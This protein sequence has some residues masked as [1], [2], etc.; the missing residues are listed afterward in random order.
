MT[1]SSVLFALG[2]ALSWTM[3]ALVSHRPATELGS[4]HFNRVRMIVATL[5]MGTL[6]IVS[7]RPAAIPPEFWLP[8]MLSAVTGVVLGDF[9]LFVTMRRLGPRRTNVLFATN[10]VFA[11]I[12]GWVIL[13][14]VVSARTAMAVLLGFGG[15]VLAVVFGKRR[16]LLHKWESVMPPLWIGVVAGLL[17]AIC[18]AFGVVFARP[19]M[20]AGVDPVAVTL[21][22]AVVGAAVFWATLPFDRSRVGMPLLPRGKL[23]ALTGLNGLFGLGVGAAML[24]AALETGNV[25]TVTILSSTTPVMIL[26]FIWART[27]RMPAPA[28][29]L[30][31]IL[32]VIC[33]MLI[34][35]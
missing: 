4:L 3:A 13:G 27:G 14:E 12:I 28:A 25:A 35:I 32:V 18:Q 10:A 17:A 34:A 7:G 23:L 22:R 8:I 24:M 6:L 30:G 5:I 21:A 9:F 1:D 33:T 15:V 29:W 2:A 31:A 16:D 19:V 11:A 26:P 20:A